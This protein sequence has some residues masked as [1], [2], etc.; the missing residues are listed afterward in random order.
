MAASIEAG[1]YSSGLLFDAARAFSQVSPDTQ[2][3]F[4]RITGSKTLG[5][6]RTFTLRGLASPHSTEIAPE[7]SLCAEV[8]GKLEGGYCVQG[9]LSQ[10]DAPVVEDRALLSV[11]K[12]E[13]RLT[14]GDLSHSHRGR[15]L[16]PASLGRGAE[17]VKTMGVVAL[18]GLVSSPTA[19]RRVE[20]I[21]GN[22]TQGPYR[23]SHFP[24]VE[25]SE[26]VEII[27]GLSRSEVP[28]EAYRLEYATGELLF[29]RDLVE[30]D[31]TI[32]VRYLQHGGE[33]IRPLQSLRTSCS[34]SDSASA[35]LQVVRTSGRGSEG[36]DIYSSCGLDSRSGSTRVRGEFAFMHS[37]SDPLK[38]AASS[39]ALSTNVRYVEFNAS[40]MSVSS[41]LTKLDGS[42]VPRRNGTVSAAITPLRRL[43]LSGEYSVV[44]EDQ[45]RTQAGCGISL[46]LPLS[47]KLACEHSAE[48]SAAGRQ[49]RDCLTL[50]RDGM[51][52]DLCA[53]IILGSATAV[54]TREYALEM[55][56]SGCS[57][58]MLRGV[59]NYVTEDGAQN[60]MNLR[61]EFRKE[62]DNIGSAFVSWHAIRTGTEAA[63]RT[64]T[65]SVKSPDRRPLQLGGT[66]DLKCLADENSVGFQLNEAHDFTGS[67][68]LTLGGF[69][70]DYH[71][72]LSVSSG[73]ELSE[74][75]IGAGWRVRAL[76]SLSA[77]AK[78][79]RYTTSGIQ[80]GA[81][82]RDVTALNCR[83]TANTGIESGI[84]YES[85]SHLNPGFTSGEHIQWRWKLLTALG[86]ESSLRLEARDAR[87]IATH[88]DSGAQLS[89]DRSVEV[90]GTRRLLSWLTGSMLAGVARKDRLD[91]DYSCFS[92]FGLEFCTT[93]GSRIELSY[94]TTLWTDLGG[95]SDEKV[96]LSGTV[97]EDWLS[98]NC[99]LEYNSVSDPVSETLTLSL[100]SS[101]HF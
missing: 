73:P 96:C 87:N 40:L 101:F 50:S 94:R 61:G 12:G 82:E 91:T 48:L 46:D 25:G 19:V 97:A 67:G 68:R 79:G 86:C 41:S 99:D 54:S 24:I 88:A 98:A 29:T 71:P 27:H 75:W 92:G 3:T 56:L 38:S 8:Y 32:E 1:D 43:R 22:G 49:V 59:F 93:R 13:D 63:R 60:K 17:F 76:G 64:I 55:D 36:A 84:E 7:Q 2:D 44:N 89:R 77:N 70:L 80:K 28:R 47:A 18:E 15:F 6:R 72:R 20:R 78:K 69:H 74:H 33:N 42:A 34:L 31:R 30:N 45:N 100:G 23:L 37:E 66:Y 26:L 39:V 14:L 35:A 51:T 53:S 10:Y 58:I 11:S 52:G 81:L 57:A 83:I 65:A 90:G 16:D 95:T 4:M 21:Q 5:Y 62:S 85:Q 9:H